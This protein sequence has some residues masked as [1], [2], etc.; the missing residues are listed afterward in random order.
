MGRPPPRR[1]SMPSLK[2]SNIEYHQSSMRSVALAFAFTASVLVRAQMPDLSAVGP[3][4]GTAAHDFAGVDQLGRAQTLQTLMGR[5]GL[6]L[7]FFRSAD[8]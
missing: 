8:W 5:D 3:K 1:L 2:H 7:V 6:M 4:I